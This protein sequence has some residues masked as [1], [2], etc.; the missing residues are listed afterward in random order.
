MANV[1]LWCISIDMDEVFND[2]VKHWNDFEGKVNKIK[3]LEGFVAVNTNG[4]GPQYYL[5]LFDTEDNRDNAFDVI[6]EI[7]KTAAIVPV[8]CVV[9]TR[10]LTRDMKGGAEMIPDE[11]IEKVMDKYVDF[12]LE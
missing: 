11:R 5:L 6:S 3:E 10:W 2:M 12:L 7:F 4:L 8:Q 1:K 9:N